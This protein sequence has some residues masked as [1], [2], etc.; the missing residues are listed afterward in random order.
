MN[1]D[2]L[3]LGPFSQS[4]L[5]KNKPEETLRCGSCQFYSDG[6]EYCY[7]K[8]EDMTISSE[9]C[10]KFTPRKESEG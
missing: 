2:K 8:S 4:I 5:A 6:G 7:I 10:V 3:L 9:A 1:E